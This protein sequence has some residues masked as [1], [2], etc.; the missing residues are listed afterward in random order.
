VELLP[1]V[2]INGNDEYFIHAILDSRIY[3]LKLQ[4]FITGVGYE[5]PDWDLTKLH[6]KSKAIDEFH[7]KN[8]D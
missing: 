4:Y 2:E 8:P 7:E 5:E 6:F 1:L 3:L